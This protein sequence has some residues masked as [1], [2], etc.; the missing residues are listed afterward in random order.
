MDGNWVA[1]THGT[2]MPVCQ[3]CRITS[4]RIEALAYK[5]ELGGGGG[6]RLRA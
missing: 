5:R 3:Q 1:H 4:D 2:Y 6:K